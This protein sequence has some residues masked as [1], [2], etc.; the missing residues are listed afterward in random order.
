M[1]KQRLLLIT[2][3]TLPVQV[4]QLSQSEHL[5]NEV[6]KNQEAVNLTNTIFDAKR[7][8]GCKFDDATVQ[9]E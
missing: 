9:S 4:M 5:I 3:A 7:L 8:I 1:E 2:K 6:S